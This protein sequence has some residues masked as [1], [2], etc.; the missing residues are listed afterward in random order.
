MADSLLPEDEIARLREEK[1]QG[2]SPAGSGCR[3]DG[4][5]PQAVSP[6]RGASIPG[7]ESKPTRRTLIQ[8][9]ARRHYEH[10]CRLH[11]M[12]RDL[13]EIIGDLRRERD[14]AYGAIRN[15]LVALEAKDVCP[16]MAEALRILVARMDMSGTIL[17]RWPPAPCDEHPKGGDPVG[18][19]GQS[20]A[21]AVRGAEAPNTLHTHPNP[22]REDR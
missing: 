21:S 12:I 22:K 10:V 1:D 17:G 9:Q 20:P 11:S 16:N 4:S 5:S 18:A 3:P 19:P 7:A 13:E 2:A 14:A 15:T 8:A 6:P